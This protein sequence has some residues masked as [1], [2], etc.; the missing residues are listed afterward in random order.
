MCDNKMTKPQLLEELIVL[1][2]K[3]LNS[4]RERN[5]YA[6]L[7]ASY[8]ELI[9]ECRD[10]YAKLD[11]HGRFI[12]CNPAY[13]Q[14][15]G[16]TEEELKA[17]AYQNI[18]PE[19]YAS[20]DQEQQKILLRDG[21]SDLYEKEYIRSDEGIIPVEIRS[22]SIK[23]ENGR[24][25]GT[26]SYVRDLT[27]KKYLE[28]QLRQSQKM[29]SLGTMA[30]EITH[31][32]GNTLNAINGYADLSLIE[33]EEDSVLYDYLLEIRN[34]GER[35]TDLVQQL[36]LFSR[37]EKVELEL[38]DPAP[39]IKQALKLI[40]VTMPPDVE[41]VANLRDDC[42]RILCNVTQ[43][44]QVV[45]N[46]VI[47]AVDALDKG[48]GKI[49][50]SCHAVDCHKCLSCMML[51]E[52]IIKAGQCF[53]LMVKD[54][55]SGIPKEILMQIFDPFYTT[56][57]EGKGTGLGLSVV[58]SIIKNH[59]GKITVNSTENEGTTFNICIPIMKE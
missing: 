35:A 32:F 7:E 23:D 58:H 41:I 16:Y 9:Q 4:E 29:E 48:K 59:K 51:D 25:E 1:R 8:F 5:R 21:V 38:V 14:I 34:A 6:D 24:F 45:V 31:E 44:H 49:T 20:V 33:L 22:Y 43:I 17:K 47:N 52:T 11:E 15:L 46:L 50:V 54:T 12:F 42:G 28:A 40:S 57:E 26:W 53:F 56:K 13:C 37:K 27:E 3:L 18:T 10:G 2:S 30:A 19:A 55:G 39:I 36:S